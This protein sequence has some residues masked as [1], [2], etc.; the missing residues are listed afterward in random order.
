MDVTS[1]DW[2]RRGRTVG[3]WEVEVEDLGDTAR[4]R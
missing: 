2:G 4:R 1:N 3:V